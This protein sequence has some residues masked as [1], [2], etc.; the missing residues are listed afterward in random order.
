MNATLLRTWRCGLAVAA[1]AA[2]ITTPGLVSGSDDA[3]K[4]ANLGEVLERAE[5]MPSDA[6]RDTDKRIAITVERVNQEARD[7]GQATM[8]ARLAAEFKVTGESLLEDKSEYSL[9]WGE[10][11]IAHT[12]LANSG[13][14]LGLV[15]LVDLRRE[16]LGW[17]AIAFGLEFH[18]E[19]FE[20]M[21]K[22]EGRVAMGLSKTGG[23]V[24]PNLK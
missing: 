20:D 12:L 17:G 2:M 13:A 19:D 6:R 15:D 9:S 23:N 8:T 18:M 24:P 10:L 3:A 11:V 5:S 16:G 1:L 7:R 22:A 4:K 21:I 14:G